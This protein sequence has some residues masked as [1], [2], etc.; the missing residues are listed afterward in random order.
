LPPD[1]LEP[2]MPQ[3]TPSQD[4]I[5]TIIRLEE[6]AESDRT[7]TERAA[8]AI[9]QFVGTL[10]FVVMQLV[11]VAVWI[12]VNLDERGFDPY[13]FPLLAGL[14][15][16]EAVVLAAFVLIRQERMSRRAD[17]RNHL[18]LQI[19]LLAEQEATKIIQMLE[20]LSRQLGVEDKVTDSE[21]KELAGDTSIDVIVHDLR[22]TLEEGETK[23]K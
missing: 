19:N 21:I 4:N 7:V 1:G 23:E 17:R 3:T 9:G 5:E 8:E 20:R 2:P 10:S 18:D 6:E 15:A 12:G 11:G 16:F 22:E 13:P 14:L